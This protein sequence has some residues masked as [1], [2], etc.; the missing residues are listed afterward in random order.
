MPL[1]QDPAHVLME[2]NSWADGKMID[3][4]QRLEGNCRV[5]TSD[6]WVFYFSDCKRGYEEYVSPLDPTANRGKKC[7]L[8]LSNWTS[9]LVKERY[10]SYLKCSYVVFFRQPDFG[11][12]PKAITAHHQRLLDF[13]TSVH[14]VFGKIEGSFNYLDRFIVDY[15]NRTV[16]QVQLTEEYLETMDRVLNLA[17]S[18][19]GG[20][21]SRLNCSFVKGLVDNVRESVC[22]NAVPSLYLLTLLLG[23]SV[24]SGLFLTAAILVL[25]RRMKKRLR[26]H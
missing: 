9:T 14:S 23:A 10:D 5:T 13:V 26:R 8:E 4:H 24:A 22:G 17:N 2:L 3:G 1:E 20:L 21:S 16:G 7:C 25:M 11:S 12:V 15:A 19:A 18:E 6:N